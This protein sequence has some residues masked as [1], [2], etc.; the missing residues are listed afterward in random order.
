MSGHDLVADG[1]T[2]TVAAVL[3]AALVEFFLDVREF[4]LGD[5]VSVVAHG[6][7]DAVAL[8]GE[9]DVDLLPVSTVG[10][11]VIE[12]VQKDLLEALRIAGDQLDLRLGRAVI[13]LDPGLA[14]QL[15]VCKERVFKL[16][17]DVQQLDAQIETSVL[18]TGEFQ[19]LLDHVVRRSASREMICTPRRESPCT[20]GS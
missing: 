13:D 2:D 17:S 1:E 19:Q 16:G 4:P 14:Y 10:H 15:A 20:A 12:Q 6:D 11:G 7:V 8:S 3:G 9:T 5:A 18:N